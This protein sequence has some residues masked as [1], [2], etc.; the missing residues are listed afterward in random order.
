M[1]VATSAIGIATMGMRA[2]RQVC[3]KTTTTM[4][5]RK[6]ASISVCCTDSTDASTYSVG[7]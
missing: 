6:I 7:L 2:A 5:T 1:N 4:T 3:R